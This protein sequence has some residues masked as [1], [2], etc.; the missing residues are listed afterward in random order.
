MEWINSTYFH[1]MFIQYTIEVVLFN[2]TNIY[3]I[4]IVPFHQ[5]TRKKKRNGI[6]ICTFASLFK[7]N[8]QKE[9]RG[10][11]CCLS[12]KIPGSWGML[13]H[14]IIRHMPKVYYVSWRNV[15]S[16]STK[17]AR[18]IT[19]HLKLFTIYFVFYFLQNTQN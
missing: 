1:Y 13:S 3:V 9:C 14:A 5:V 18:K 12:C 17:F 10:K 2:F 16:V 11:D 19:Q 4:R 8:S 6:K 7:H 15:V